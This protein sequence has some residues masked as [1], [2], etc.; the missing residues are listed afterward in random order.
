MKK[1]KTYKNVP[2]PPPLGTGGV[3][4]FII[5]NHQKVSLTLDYVASASPFLY[6]HRPHFSFPFLPFS[7]FA[8][9]GQLTRLRR[10]GIA[11][12]EAGRKWERWTWET[13]G[14]WGQWLAGWVIYGVGWEWRY[15]IPSYYFLSALSVRLSREVFLFILTWAIVFFAAQVD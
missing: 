9:L 2:P 4:S 11:G 7:F 5:Q 3:V 6:G 10:A 15:L 14:G 8:P 1:G 13:E 12:K